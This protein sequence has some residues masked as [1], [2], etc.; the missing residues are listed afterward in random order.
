MTDYS[1]FLNAIKEIAMIDYNKLVKGLRS[2]QHPVDD[3]LNAANAREALSAEVNKLSAEIDDIKQK[4]FPAR[5]DAINA[6]ANKKNIALRSENDKLSATIAAHAGREVTWE[7]LRDAHSSM[8]GEAPWKRNSPNEG[9]R[10][11]LQ[12]GGEQCYMCAALDLI[13]KAQAENVKLRAAP[14][15]AGGPTGDTGQ[16]VQPESRPFAVPA[17]AKFF[18]EWMLPTPDDL[19]YETGCGARSISRLEHP[20]KLPA[21]CQKCYMPIR[22]KG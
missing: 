14:A 11:Y 6:A 4:Q 12:T 10:V 3:I 15:M 2:R 22:L 5:C 17:P 7:R 21:T 13:E 1:N 18:C 20:L 9:H 8:L 16:S 19:K